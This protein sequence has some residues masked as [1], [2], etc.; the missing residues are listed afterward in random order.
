M[1]MANLNIC[2]I[3][4]GRLIRYLKLAYAKSTPLLTTCFNRVRGAKWLWLI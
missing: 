4:W 1:A 2:S 3:G